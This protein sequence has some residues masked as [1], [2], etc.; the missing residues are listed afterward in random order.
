[1]VLGLLCL[2]SAPALADDWLPHSS[3]AQWQYRLTDSQYDKAGTVENV[4]VSQ[5]SDM[6]FTLAWAGVGTT[7]PTGGSATINCPQTT[8]AAD[9]GTMSF[10]DTNAG[11]INT[12]WNSCPPPPQFPVLC[13]TTSLCEQPRRARSTTSSGGDR[14]PV[15][16][17]PLLQGTTWTAT[18]GAPR[19][20]CRA[21][22]NTW[23]RASSRC[24]P[25]RRGC[26][27]R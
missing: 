10:Q 26:V 7:P 11:L 8:P 12:D 27:R 14:V 4:V 24:P 19:T 17:E 20:T 15:L 22:R 2:A 13:P 3:D 16:S 25:F 23:E 9:I 21:R 1:M 18:E 5:Q 6:T